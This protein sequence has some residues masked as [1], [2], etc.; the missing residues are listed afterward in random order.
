MSTRHHEV[1]RRE[2]AVEPAGV[3]GREHRVAG[4]GDERADLTVARRLDL[5]GERRRPGA[6][7]RTRAGRAPG[8]AGA[9]SARRGRRPASRPA[10]SAP[11]FAPPVAGSVNIAPPS[12]SRLP[13]STLTTS[14]SHDASVPNSW[15]QV[16]MRP[17]TAARSVAASSRA[18]RRIVVGVDAADRRD[19]LGREV[20]RQRARPR[21]ARRR[22]PRHGAEVDETLGEE[23][24]H[25]PEEEVRVGAGPDEEVLVGFL[26]GLR[27]ARVDDDEPAA[28]RADRAQPARARR[29]RS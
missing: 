8:C 26:R 7:R 5:L 20:A 3:R 1:E 27:P 15:V 25:E 18:T 14:T 28:A 22:D 9:R 29:A 12:R 4:D 13:A 6:R 24:V 17:Y 21:R 11:A 23:R 10:W 19:D 16:P 2:R